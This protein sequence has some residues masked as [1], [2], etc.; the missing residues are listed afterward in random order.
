MGEFSAYRAAKDA[1]VKQLGAEAEHLHQWA[2]A[3][4]LILHRIEEGAYVAG[5]RRLTPG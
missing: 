4:N 5:Q 2:L 3:M 1:E